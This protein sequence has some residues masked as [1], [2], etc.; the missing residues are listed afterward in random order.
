VS[1]GNG[2]PVLS[3]LLQSL[4][5]ERL[6]GRLEKSKVDAL[7]TQPVDVLLQDRATQWQLSSVIQGIATYLRCSTPNG[8]AAANCSPNLVHLVVVGWRAR[9]FPNR[10]LDVGTLTLWAA[11]NCPQQLYNESLGN[12]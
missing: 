12:S 9:V 1:D 5:P 3:R 6:G 10:P 11:A 7:V 2:A 8:A 4:A